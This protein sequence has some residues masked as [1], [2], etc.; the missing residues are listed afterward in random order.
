MN[1]F[2]KNKINVNT[3]YF[4]IHMQPYYRKNKQLGLQE[5]FNYYFKSFSI[6][7]YYGLSK[8]KQD[9]VIDVITKLFNTNILKKKL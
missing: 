5:S 8:K 3:H 9:K 6:P 1:Y 4:P 2:H 7:I